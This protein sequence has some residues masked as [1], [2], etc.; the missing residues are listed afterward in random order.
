MHDP[1]V[2]LREKQ[3]PPRGDWS[4]W[5][6]KCGRGFGKTL[7]GSYWTNQ[8]AMEFPGRWIALVAQK[9]S[10]ARDYMIEGPGG[11]LK[12]IRRSE[13]PDY[14]PSKRRLSWPNGSWATIYS[15]EEPDQLR[16]FSGDTA[17]LDEFAKF[18]NP[19]EVWEQLQFGMRERSSDRP[20]CLITTTPRP[21]QILKS[22]ER[23]PTTAT[24]EG[25]SYENR[26]NLDAKWFSGLVKYEGTRIG[27]QEIHGEILEDVSGALWSRD[28]IEKL[29][30]TDLKLVP[31]M[32]RIVVAIDPAATSGEDADETGIIVAGL[33]QDGHGYVLDDGSGRMVPNEWAGRALDLASKREWHA[34][35]IVAEVNNGGEMVENTLRVIE[36]EVNF[37]A[38]H[39]SRG[40]V[41]RAEPISTLYEQG[42]VHHVQGFPEL[43]D[44]LCS[45]TLAFDRKAAG[46]SPDRLDALVWAFTELMVDQSSAEGWIDFYSKLA[47]QAMNGDAPKLMKPPDRELP[48][49]KRNQ[50]PPADPDNTIVETYN[51]ITG[52]VLEQKTVCGWC[53][54]VVGSSRATDGE[55]IFH[56]SCYTAM[57]NSPNRR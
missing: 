55:N 30:V 15:S 35:L 34:E 25:S 41:T 1:E 27:R 4:V 8:R 36:P 16:G 24:V 14:E 13:R 51:R 22:I 17:W 50:P 10:D 54:E 5:L 49:H 43:E 2:W 53:E 37:K 28:Q 7:T 46:Y 26:D 56:T 23:D 20:R 21:L 42:L 44:Q 32:R 45:F 11:L 29:R 47:Q 52:K 33:G 6:L 3:R 19:K 31:T 39:A 40:K 12:N 9:P 48:L 38:V 57:L 18:P